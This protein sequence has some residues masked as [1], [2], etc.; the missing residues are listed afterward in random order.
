MVVPITHFNAQTRI[1]R[2]RTLPAEGQIFV[3]RDQK[4]NASDS[5]GTCYLPGRH[6]MVDLYQALGLSR[7]TPLDAISDRKA[8][9]TL[10]K[11]DVLAK[12]GKVFKRIVRTPGD[13]YIESIE[14]GKVL[15]EILDPP[16]ELKAGIDGIIREVTPNWS[17]VVETFGCL[18]QGVW[19]NGKMA[20][21]LLYNTAKTETEEFTRSCVDVTMRG[22]VVAGG[23]CVH[24]DALE[25]AFDFSLRGL[26][27][28]SI[29]SHLIGYVQQLEIPVILLE[30]FGAIPFNPLAFQLLEKYNRNDASVNACEWDVYGGNRP[31]VVIPQPGSGADPREGGHIRQGSRVRVMVPPYS[32]AVGIVVL[33]RE[34]STTIHSGLRGECADVKFDRIPTTSFPVSNLDILE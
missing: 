32:G 8:G 31:E 6:E 25:A 22:A 23:F 27:L 9:E 26:I 16:I 29:S 2:T 30:G 1:R 15:L 17:A 19:G 12:T 5:V 33:I 21:G 14:D 4:V 28:S 11:G 3:R 18:I 13:C 24:Q 20:S 34:G 10:Q 7:K